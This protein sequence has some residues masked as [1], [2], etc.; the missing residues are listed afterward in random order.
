MLM[1]V[2]QQSQG[3][4]LGVVRLDRCLLAE[5]SIDGSY[6]WIRWQLIITIYW[7]NLRNIEDLNDTERNGNTLT[8]E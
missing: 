6:K 2:T 7:W 3:S 5:V 4:A 1:S 8:L